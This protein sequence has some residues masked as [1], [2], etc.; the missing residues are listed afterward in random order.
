MRRV[1]RG[2]SAATMECRTQ[3]GGAAPR[4]RAKTDFEGSPPCKGPALF[5]ILLW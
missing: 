5:L 2:P 3:Q 1:W 4:L